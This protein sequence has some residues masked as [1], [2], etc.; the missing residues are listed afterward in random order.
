MQPLIRLTDQIQSSCGDIQ[1]KEESTNNNSEQ[2]SLMS[3]FSTETKEGWKFGSGATLVVNNMNSYISNKHNAQPFPTSRNIVERALHVVSTVPVVCSSSGESSHSSIERTP[4]RKVAKKR[5]GQDGMVTIQN[6]KSNKEYLRKAQQSL[7]GSESESEEFESSRRSS[8]EV[9]QQSQSSLLLSTAKHTSLRSIR[10]PESRRRHMLLSSHKHPMSQSESN[11]VQ[12]SNPDSSLCSTNSISGGGGLSNP[13]GYEDPNATIVPAPFRRVG[14]AQRRGSVTKFSLQAA[15]AAMKATERIKRLNLHQLTTSSQGQNNDDEAVQSRSLEIDKE[16][17]DA[18]VVQRLLAQSNNNMDTRPR[19]PRRRPSRKS[20]P[21][22][23]PRKSVADRSSLE[24]DPPL[25]QTS[26]ANNDTSHTDTTVSP[27]RKLTGILRMPKRHASRED[28]CLPPQPSQDE[29]SGDSANP[30]RYEDPDAAATK[31]A[32]PYG[33]EDMNMDND[34]S[35]NREAATTSTDTTS[36]NPYGYEDPD[37]TPSN[38]YG[39]GDTQDFKLGFGASYEQ[40]ACRRRHPG[41]KR[42]GS[43]T[44][45][46]LEAQAKVVESEADST[47][48]GSVSQPEDADTLASPD[49]KTQTTGWQTPTTSP[50]TAR[51]NRLMAKLSSG[52]PMHKQ[53]PKQTLDDS[54][55]DESFYGDDQVVKLNDVEDSNEDAH[56]KLNDSSSSL[57]SSSLNRRMR[58]T[59]SRSGSWRRAFASKR[60]N[61]GISLESADSLADDLES[62]CSISRHGDETDSLPPPPPPAVLNLRT[63]TPNQ[64]RK[65]SLLMTPRSVAKQAS[66]NLQLDT[67]VDF[68]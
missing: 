59:P 5:R 18:A 2:W 16:T 34:R 9:Q 32:N 6:S 64:Q 49:A 24:L 42:R 41:P 47:P 30:Y 56:V 31:Q 52:S 27:R 13:Y 20:S 58:R 51:R 65:P 68:D 11:V 63:N 35:S 3:G 33:Y 44:K 43:V 40:P 48:R 12:S 62:L 57:G 50:F 29:P 25:L 19:T 28:L 38:P 54:S 22:V 53:S 55:S 17:L 39:Y 21:V 1:G 66:F 67:A 8:S 37:A 23:M 46:S 60:S 4:S 10:Q 61:S 15:A 7:R 14:P 36:S 26:H 45:Y